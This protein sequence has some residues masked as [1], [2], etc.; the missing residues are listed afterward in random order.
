ME[1][2]WLSKHFVAKMNISKKI[3]TG[4]L[5][6]KHIGNIV[7]LHQ[8]NLLSKIEFFNGNLKWLEIA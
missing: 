1:Y 2:Y 7:C 6:R 4:T 3:N 8:S 5:Q